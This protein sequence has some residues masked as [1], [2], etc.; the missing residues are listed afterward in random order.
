MKSNAELYLLLLLLPITS[1]FPQKNPIII[2]E[3]EFIAHT[4]ERAYFNSP[5]TTYNGAIYISYIDKNLQLRVARKFGDRWQ[6]TVVDSAVYPSTWHSAASIGID[7]KGFVHV[8]GNMHSSP[9]QYHRSKKPEDISQWEFLGQFAGENKGHR[10]PGADVRATWM[11]RGSAAIP[12]N[13]IT[14]PYFC[15][16]RN[17]RLYVAYRECYY[18]DRSNYFR[19]EWSGGLAAYDARRGT[20]Q[21]VGGTRPWA[22]DKNYVPLGMRMAFDARNRMHVSWLWYAHYKKDGSHDRAPNFPAYLM[23]SHAGSY[24]QRSDLPPVKL[25]VDISQTDTLWSP[26]ELAQNAT[27]YF[28]RHTDLATPP[29]V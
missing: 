4:A 3:G 23:R 24:F 9:W 25:P 15:N 29:N 17:G 5:V 13:Q 14:Y 2:Q 12:G 27:G 1:L 21:R 7:E 20:W 11:T 22:N 8:V 10:I 19:R 16:D 26:F 6:E 28:V 18:C